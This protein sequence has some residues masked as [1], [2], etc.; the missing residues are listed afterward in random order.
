MST[1][2][3]IALVA[4]GATSSDTTTAAGGPP[5]TTA[6]PAAPAASTSASTGITSASGPGTTASPAAP[7]APSAPDCPGTR[8]DARAQSALGVADTNRPPA[9]NVTKDNPN[10]AMFDAIHAY[11]VDGAGDEYV[12]SWIDRSKAGAPI[13]VAFTDHV[14]AHRAALL[15]ARAQPGGPSM[16]SPSGRVGPGAAGTRPTTVATTLAEAGW[17]IEVIQMNDATSQVRGR[18]NRVLLYEQGAGSALG[19]AV[20]NNVND[21]GRLELSLPAITDGTRRDLAVRFGPDTICLR[22]SRRAP[23]VS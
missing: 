3:G 23:A 7:A 19:L 17:P 11:A 8:P 4:C 15:A 14:D 12:D 16:T 20:S 21:D 6:I 5:G 10:P 18:R 1:M 22:L 9:P 13:V 2:L